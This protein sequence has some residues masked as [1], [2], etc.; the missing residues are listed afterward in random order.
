MPGAIRRRRY[1]V[2]PRKFFRKRR[3]RTDF[4]SLKTAGEVHLCRAAFQPQVE[5]EKALVRDPEQGLFVSTADC[6]KKLFLQLFEF[7]VIA[8]ENFLSRR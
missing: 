1:L 7:D 4:R 5:N 8:D 2:S 6:V 3:S